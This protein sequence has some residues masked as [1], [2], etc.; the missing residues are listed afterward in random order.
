MYHFNNREELEKFFETEVLTTTE[1]LKLLGI[2]RQALNQAVAE[3]RLKPIKT[4]ERITLFLRSD[5]E[6]YK[7][8]SRSK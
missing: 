6:Q 4:A 3:G 8:K 7:P 2:S 1:T 5:V